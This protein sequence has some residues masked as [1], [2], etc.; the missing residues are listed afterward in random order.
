MS[1]KKQKLD[2]INKIL[3]IFLGGIG[4]LILFTPA[5]VALRQRF[6]KAHFAFM[7]EPFKSEQVIKGSPYVDEI[8]IY[9]REQY[10]TPWQT[11]RFIKMLRKKKFDLAIVGAGMNPIR[12]GILTSLIGARYRVGENVKGWGF[13]FNVKAEPSEE[14]HKIEGNIGLVEAMGLKVRS[15]KLMV[16]VSDADRRFSQEFFAN[17]EISEKD[18]LIGLHPG[19]KPQLACK[20]WSKSGFAQV[21]DILTQRYGA[22]ILIVGGPDELNLCKEVAAQMK[23]KPVIAAGNGRL[24][25]TASLIERCDL[26]IS[27]DSGPMHIAAAMDTAVVAIFGPTDPRKTAPY[28]FE[29]IFVRKDLR[30]SPCYKYRKIKCEK[31]D[32][33]R[34]ITV[35]DVVEAAEKQLK[36]YSAKSLL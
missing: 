15:K 11:F 17:H 18:L 1:V 25:Q 31:L 10:R 8:I 33:L 2:D 20:R 22:K 24:G 6:T 32:C 34:L 9:D 21:G 5:L 3:V 14:K 16:W 27:N 7:V 23:L 19:S 26:F 12:G 29:H 13:L 35:E 36:R 4:D 30:C 28:G